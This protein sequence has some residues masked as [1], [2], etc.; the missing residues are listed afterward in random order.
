MMTGASIEVMVGPWRVHD[1]DDQSAAEAEMSSL[2][3]F[4]E[5]IRDLLLLKGGLGNAKTAV[6]IYRT[7]HFGVEWKK[8]M[9]L[10]ESDMTR[11]SVTWW[12]EKLDRLKKMIVA[13]VREE[14]G[15]YK[16]TGSLYGGAQYVRYYV[17]KIIQD[18]TVSTE[19]VHS[20]FDIETSSVNLSGSQPHTDR[21]LITGL[22]NQLPH[23]D[24]RWMAAVQKISSPLS[25]NPVG[26]KVDTAD[27][28]PTIIA[29]VNYVQKVCEALTGAKLQDQV[30]RLLQ[31]E[32]TFLDNQRVAK[33]AGERDQAKMKAEL[34][35]AIAQMQACSNTYPGTNDT[36]TRTRRGPAGVN[37]VEEVFYSPQGGGQTYGS[38]SQPA[39]RDNNSTRWGIAGV[40]NVNEPLYP[41][42]GGG[43][44]YGN[45]SQS[46]GWDNCLPPYSPQSRSV[47]SSVNTIS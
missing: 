28:F 19:F 15:N 5:S 25:L 14:I 34:Q 12:G 39:F 13:E 32:R 44:P 36:T 26:I 4:K 3:R 47:R 40:N 46:A 42:Q 45:G 43:Q 16:N 37:H 23:L 24:Q 30:Q 22:Y 7:Y 11:W 35:E 10:P 20:S 8:V 38:G 41:S 33:E 2:V 31:G 29:L 9:D 18:G 27:T 17:D 6:E 1:F 21:T